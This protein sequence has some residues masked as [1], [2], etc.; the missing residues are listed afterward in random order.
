MSQSRIHDVKK[1]RK[2]SL[3]LREL[4]AIVQR[5]GGEE[6][7]IA[8]VFVSRVDLTDDYGACYVYLVPYTS[9][10]QEIVDMAIEKLI[11]YKPSIRR[12]IAESINPRYT[13][14]IRFFFDEV[15][16][17]QYKIDQL[18]DKVH[19]ELGATSPTCDTSKK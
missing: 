12:A 15:K 19:E 2:K 17:K 11:L 4:A 9:F 13:P 5:L 3:F 10:S 16:E 8:Q 6:P 7:A 18:L 1:E 14:D